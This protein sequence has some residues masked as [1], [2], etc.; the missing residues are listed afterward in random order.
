MK[1]YSPN[2]CQVQRYSPEVFTT[3]DVLGRQIKEFLADM[4]G[5]GLMLGYN[6]QVNYDTAANQY[7]V[8]TSA[9]II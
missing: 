7:V 8:T 2:H 4:K 6:V 9:E 1:P 5:K 3:T